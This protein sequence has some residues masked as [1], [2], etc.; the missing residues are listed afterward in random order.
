MTSDK[1]IQ[2]K[3]LTMCSMVQYKQQEENTFSLFFS[4]IFS[5]FF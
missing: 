4:V 1:E 3:G 2:Y 5:N